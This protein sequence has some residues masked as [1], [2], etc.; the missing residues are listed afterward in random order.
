MCSILPHS[1]YGKMD[2]RKP[3]LPYM[4]QPT[5]NPMDNIHQCEMGTCPFCR[6]F[7]Q[8]NYAQNRNLDSVFEYGGFFIQI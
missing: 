6:Y 8:S 4:S 3:G 7:F 2:H 1:M 5:W